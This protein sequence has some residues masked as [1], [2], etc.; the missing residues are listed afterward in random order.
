MFRLYFSTSNVTVFLGRDTQEGPNPHEVSRSVSLVVKHPDYDE[1]TKDND[2]ALLRLSSAVTF[3]D[4]VRPVCLAAERSFFP[5][6]LSSW[7][8]GWGDVQTGGEDLYYI[9]YNRVPEP[10]LPG[11][12]DDL[13]KKNKKKI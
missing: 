8:T 5:A 1:R 6:G 11:D 4:F 10:R 7:V 2:I 3:S 9:N 12:S 13:K